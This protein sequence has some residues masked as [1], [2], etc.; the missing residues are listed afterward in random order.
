MNCVIA[1]LLLIFITVVACTL[2][3]LWLVDYLQKI[4][5]KIIEETE[6]FFRVV[7]KTIRDSIKKW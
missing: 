2:V 5:V 4:F 7:D 1:V 6:K 3:Y